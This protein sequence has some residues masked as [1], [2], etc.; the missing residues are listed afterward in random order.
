MADLHAQTD[1]KGGLNGEEAV[2]LRG[3]RTDHKAQKVT[4]MLD[5]VERGHEGNRAIINYNNR[6]GW[7]LYYKVSNEFAPEIMKTVR[8]FTDKNEIQKEFKKIMHQI[9]IKCFGIKYK[10]CKKVTKNMSKYKHKAVKDLSDQVKEHKKI[11]YNIQEKMKAEKALAMKVKIVDK[12]LRGP[13]HK[14]P[15]RT[16]IFDPQTEELITDENEILATTL[17][18]NIGVLTKNKVQKQDLPE[19]EQKN[20]EHEK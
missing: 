19:V 7:K 1:K 20:I 5:L 16:A 3:K 18:Y 13:K 11:D 6:D 10:K 17:K 8:T 2:Y 15:E 4:L 14:V 9:D 12:V